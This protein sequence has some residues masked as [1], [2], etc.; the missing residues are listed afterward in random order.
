MDPLSRHVARREIADAWLEGSRDR[1]PR[2]LRARGLVAPLQAGEDQA[3]LLVEEVE[4]FMRRDLSVFGLEGEL[5]EILRSG[6][7]PLALDFDLD[8]TRIEGRRLLYRAG[9]GPDWSLEWR[10]GRRLRARDLIRGWV[11]H[12]AVCACR[13][14]ARMLLVSLEEYALIEGLRAPEAGERLRNLLELMRQGLRE[15]LPF[16]PETSWAYRRKAHGSEE[17]ALAAAE[18]AWAGSPGARGDGEDPYQRRALGEAG[19]VFHPRF[20]EVAR[21]VFDPLL[22]KFPGVKKWTRP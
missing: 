12:L 6:G 20:P 3:R 14:E 22:E 8:G 2:S 1:L 19:P 10:P 16:A 21:A 7:K 11:A 9:S 4:L 15:P 17:E 5:S 18:K 13:E